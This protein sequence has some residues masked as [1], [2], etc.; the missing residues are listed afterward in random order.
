[1]R[2]LN[3]SFASPFLWRSEKQRSWIQNEEWQQLRQ[4]ILTRDKFTCQYCNYKSDKYQ[5]VDHRDGNP[6]NNSHK[7]L[8]VICQMC[9]LVKHSGQGC[10]IQKIVDLYKR[11]QY[12]QNDIIRITRFLRDTGKSD[13][14]IIRYIGLKEKVPFRMDKTYLNPLFAFI[15][16]RKSRTDM[17]SNWLRYHNYR[18]KGQDK[19]YVISQKLLVD[20]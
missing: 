1:M 6:K 12:R 2:N 18:N 4:Q 5:I 10:E 19:E 14:E 9:N 13:P 20:F 17:Y 16:S 15:T 3:P 7:N 8:Q 11:S